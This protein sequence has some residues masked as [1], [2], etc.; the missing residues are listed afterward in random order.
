[1][2][3]APAVCRDLDASLRV[4]RVLGHEQHRSIRRPS[5][6]HMWAYI[7]TPYPGASA[8]EV[9]QEVTDV[10]ETALQELPYLQQMKSNQSRGDQKFKQRSMS[11]STRAK[12]LKFGMKCAAE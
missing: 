8:Q 10:V 12:S 2:D 4:G 7:I 9:E 6:S 5:V 3:R 1:M 11:A